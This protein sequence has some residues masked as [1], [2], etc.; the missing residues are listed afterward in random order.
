L[1]SHQSEVTASPAGQ[2]PGAVRRNLAEEV[3]SAL[4]TD[5]V[6]GKLAPG[7]LL[8]ESALATRFGA[9]RTPVREALS[10][11]AT[12]GL[13]TTL[14]QR[15]HVVNTVTLAEALDAF[16][17]RG[18]LEAEAAT[19]AARRINDAQ[20]A[21]L[22]QL[23]EIRES[24]DLPAVNREFHTGIARIS[25]NRLLVDFVDRLLMC[26]ERILLLGPRATTWTQDGYEEELAIVEALAAHDEK[27]AQE[28]VLR[29]VQ[30]SL[31]LAL[32]Q[33]D[34]EPQPALEPQP[35]RTGILVQ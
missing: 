27:A 3:Y 31:A 22:R 25:G 15:G 21:H 2:D 10:V 19:Q 18:I 12:D 9:S 32:R 26:M 16:R 33:S 6:K 4:K 17:L 11:L 34:Q 28:A 7:S 23:I 30:S 1:I 14:P 5:I 24:D 8:S 20:I 29:H 13:V 35:A